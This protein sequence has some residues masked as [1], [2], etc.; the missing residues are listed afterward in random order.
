MT[1]I[2]CKKIFCR[3]RLRSFIL[4]EMEREEQERETL[5]A[6]FII[7]ILLLILLLWQQKRK[8]TLAICHHQNKKKKT[9]ENQLTMETLAKQFIGKECI[10]YTVTDTSAAIQ[11]TLK[12]VT[13][14]GLILENKE[15]LQAINLE[16]ITRIREY[17]RNSKGKKK[18]IVI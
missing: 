10:I 14:G 16:Y 1:G 2:F 12:E 8:R 13:D 3:R 11:G 17:P 9:K 7:L 5:D 6:T 18:A 15:G 4:P